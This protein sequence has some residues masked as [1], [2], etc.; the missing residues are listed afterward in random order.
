MRKGAVDM[1]EKSLAR[2]A[3]SAA[4]FAIDRPYDYLIPDKL[5]GIVA[6]G[7]RVIVPFGRGNRRCEAIVLSVYKYDGDSVL[8]TVESV[9]EPEPILSD[10]Q[11]KL[12]LW[13]RDRFFCTVYD[14]VHAMLPSGIWYKEGGHMIKDKTVTYLS[15][16]IAPEDAVSIAE[17][18]RTRAP[19]QASILSLMASIGTAS[20]REVLYFTGASRQSAT[21][22]IKQGILKS[23]EIEVFRRPKYYI[24]EPAAEIALNKSQKRAFDGIMCQINDELPAAAL[25]FGVTGSGKTSVYINVIKEIIRKGKT[26]IVLVPEIALTPQLVS[27]FSAHFGD[28]IAVLHS[29]LG[30]GERYDEWKRIRSGVVKVVIGT[31]SAVFAPLENLGLIVIDEEQEYTYKSENAPRYHARDVA[32]Y[33]CVQ[34]EAFLLLGSA[35]PD[36][37][38][39]YNAKVGRYALYTLD[40]RYNEADLPEVILADMK[41]EIRRGN[42]TYISVA[43]R[44]ELEKNIENGEQSILF[45]NRRGASNQ[46]VC[47]DCGYIYT[48]TNCSVSMTYHSVNNRLMCHYCGRSIP[49]DSRCPE[50]GGALKFVGV[51]TQKIEEELKK[52]FP[53]VGIIRM[54]TD[55]VSPSYSHEKLLSKFKNENIPILVGTQMVTKGLDF[56]NVTLVGVVLADQSLYIN[57][58]RAYERTFSLITQV[59]GRSGRGSKPGRAVIQTFT[60]KNEIIMLASTQDYLRFYEREIETRRIQNCPPAAD[61]FV[62]TVTG[63]H[64]ENVL[65]GCTKLCKSLERYLSDLRGVRILGPAPAAVTKIKNKFRYRITISSE[66]TKRIRNTISHLIREFSKDKMNRGLSIFAD[67][68]PSD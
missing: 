19:Q 37:E 33:R 54:D 60:P 12:A 2:V 21:A 63:Q 9:I 39:M 48:C 17:K 44:R 46:V 10:A 65:R 7:V 26:A 14:A 64:E 43:L 58:Y 28:E 53:G 52:I 1:N 67:V 18:K 34:S 11:I 22:L 23:E 41:D 8:K 13:M 57:D 30:I 59:V 16:D 50:C 3:V 56:E 15:L 38:S 68:N 29:S 49:V 35:T 6:P 55:T 27:R 25:L 47:G 5:S 66:N 4:T 45:I 42:G 36:I 51:G 62:I 24:S 32:K 31:R 40:T 20:M 61:L